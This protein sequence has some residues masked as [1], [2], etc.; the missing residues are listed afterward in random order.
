M[1]TPSPAGSRSEAV[2]IPPTLHGTIEVPPDARALVVFAH[3]SGSSRLSPRNR[4]VASALRDAGL[5]TL[6]FDL[7]AEEEASDRR[8]V[9]DIGLLAARLEGAVDFVAAHPLAAGLPLGLFGASTAIFLY[10]LTV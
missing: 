2:V 10:K 5:G 3:G 8:K 4:G 7:L 9:F 6:L 1:S